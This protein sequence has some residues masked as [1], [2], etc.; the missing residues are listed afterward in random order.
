MVSSINLNREGQ[1]TYFLMTLLQLLLGR[2]LNH[3]L[4]SRVENFMAVTD[5]NKATDTRGTT[6]VGDVKTTYWVP[7]NPMPHLDNELHTETST[8]V[9]GHTPY[10]I[11]CNRILSETGKPK[12]PITS[13]IFKYFHY[14]FCIVFMR[15]L[16]INPRKSQIRPPTP[17]DPFSQGRL[18]SNDVRAAWRRAS[19]NFFHL[20][21]ADPV[22]ISLPSCARPGFIMLIPKC[23]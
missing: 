18:N 4:R 10:T 9:I 8:I 16:Y 2:F 13:S 17:L 22:L 21:M 12:W 7:D 3:N 20:S 5:E 23:E 1:F 14:G 19:K 11:N 6:D 15:F